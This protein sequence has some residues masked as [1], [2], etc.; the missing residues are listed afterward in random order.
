MLPLCFPA[1]TPVLT[2]NGLIPIEKIR[3]GDRVISRDPVTGLQASRTV[4]GTTSSSP[5]HLF[6]IHYQLDAP[7][8][9]AEAAW[10]ATVAHRSRPRGDANGDDEPP[11]EI[12]STGTHP[13][14]VEQQKAFVEAANLQKGDRLR[15]A[16]GGTAQVLTVEMETAPTGEHFVTYNLDV[17]DFHTYFAGPDASGFTTMASPAKSLTQPSSLPRHLQ[18]TV[19]P[20]VSKFNVLQVAFQA[21]WKDEEA[22]RLGFTVE[23]VSKIFREFME[24]FPGAIPEVRR[25]SDWLTNPAVKWL[26]DRNIQGH[27]W[28][29]VNWFGPSGGGAWMEGAVSPL[30]SPIAHTAKPD[31]VHP[32]MFKYFCEKLNVNTQEGIQAAWEAG[33]SSGRERSPVQRATGPF[34]KFLQGDLQPRHAALQI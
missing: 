6:H 23:D 13:F 3:A 28:W 19:G 29:P 22:A 2:P 5:N 21:L 18:Q 24:E 33:Q 32:A 31:G 26:K 9:P 8:V 4:L 12:V 27:H 10:A 34:E 16:N 1:G 15:L 11:A 14:W 25:Y 17:Q 30:A 7:S 20:N